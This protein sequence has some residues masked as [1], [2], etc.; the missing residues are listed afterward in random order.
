MKNVW[1]MVSAFVLVAI[2][3][4]CEKD[5]ELG[6]S[7]FTLA[8]HPVIGDEALVL[9]QE[10]L[11]QENYRIKPATLKF[12]V[13]NVVLTTA[14]GDIK[15][16]DLDLL[17]MEQ[18]E[19]G[20]P[21]TFEVEVPAGDYTG[22]S[23]WV[24]L[25][26]LQNASDPATFAN[27]HPLSLSTGTF[28]TWNTGYRFVMLEGYYDDVQNT[29]GPVSTSR[30]FNYHTGT[31]PLYKQAE[32]G[33]ANVAFTISEGERFTYNLDLDVNKMFYGLENIDRSQGAVT[34][35]TSN[36]PLAQKFTENFVRAF[37]LSAP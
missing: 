8:V 21:L 27:G 5:P 2:M 18:V 30:F 17:D 6:A 15:I 36:Y 31:A 25:D 3:S 24:G 20:E 32:L 4:S 22:I 11:D 16:L 28:W 13:S 12:Y 33:A 37:S 26:S 1:L 35:T 19:A 34:H 29:P 23:F 9:N 14:S 10:Y 7:T